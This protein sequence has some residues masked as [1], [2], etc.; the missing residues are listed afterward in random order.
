MIKNVTVLVTNKCN[1]RC[2]MCNIW[3][4]KTFEKEMT[5]AEYKKLFSKPEFRET[6]DL[7]ISG[8]EPTQRKDITEIIDVMLDN[9]P[10]VHMFFLS[11]N[12]TN[13]EKVRDLFLRY[14]KCIKDVYACISIEGNKET[15]KK[16]RGIDNYDSAIKTIRLCKE[17]NLNIHSIISMTLTSA[18]SNKESLNHIKKIAEETGSTYSFRKVWKNDTYYHNCANKKI[19]ISEKQRREVID[20]MEKYCTT[21]LFMKAQIKY[22]KSNSMPMMKK[23]YAGDIFVLV[24]PDGSVYP[25]INSSRKI[26]DLER[27]IFIKNIEDLGKY[28]SCPC[29]TECCFYPMLNWSLYSTRNNA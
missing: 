20:F 12:G 25:C 27:G 9:M 18:N 23:C 19:D 14:S 2:M 11:T 5:V 24:R 7:N 3:N 15:N 28:E 4:T 17:T 26:G 22:F 21:D 1:S 13:P 8:G 29:C 16:V 10:K 6:E